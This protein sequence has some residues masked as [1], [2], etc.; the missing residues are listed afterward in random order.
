MTFIK[1]D[2]A[3]FNDVAKTFPTFRG[4]E[5]KRSYE[6]YIALFSCCFRLIER[7]AFLVF[8]KLQL[9][10][11]I[12]ILRPNE[13]VIVLLLLFV[14]GTVPFL[15]ETGLIKELTCVVLKVGEVFYV[16]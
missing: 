13:R 3:V 1:Y 10:F 15:V 9:L 16:T 4:K 11:Q 7:T 6:Y 5:H 2:Y 8:S 12:Q 14:V